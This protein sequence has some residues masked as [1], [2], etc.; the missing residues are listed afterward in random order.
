MTTLTIEQLKNAYSVSKDHKNNAI[1]R[2]RI[3]MAI[4]EKKIKEFSKR[5][6]K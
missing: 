6:K 2:Y 4:K 3:R 1:I 5:E